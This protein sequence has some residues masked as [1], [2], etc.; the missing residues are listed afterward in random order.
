MAKII[1]RNCRMYYASLAL[2]SSTNQVE[3]SAT[4]PE[5]AIDNFGGNGWSEA[6]A[7]IL[8]TT[9]NFQ[10]FWGAAD[11]DATLYDKLGD[12]DAPA[13]VVQFPSGS[14]SKDETGA[15]FTGFIL[16]AAGDV[17]YFSRCSQLSHTV[18][19]SIG[20]AAKITLNLKGNQPL[21]RGKVL[22]YYQEVATTGDGTAMLVGA[23]TA[24]QK[25]WFALHV[26]RV[27]GTLPTLDLVLSSDDAVGMASAT[28]RITVPQITTPGFYFG[29]VAGPITDTYYQLVH[30]ISGTLPKFDYVAAIGIL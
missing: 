27:S 29:S 22:E 13:T 2:A 5:V 1:L 8:S 26:F 30:T 7:G 17:A 24:A 18:G 4:A 6:L 25:L 21:V 14:G 19:G 16:P 15:A 10:G 3:V 12:T 11:P 28:T 9:M 20:A 23:T